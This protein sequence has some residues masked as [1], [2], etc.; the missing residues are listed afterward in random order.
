MGSSSAHIGV[1]ATAGNAARRA[2]VSSL[3]I[4]VGLLQDGG[5]DP[6]SDGLQGLIEDLDNARGLT[7][8]DHTPSLKTQVERPPTPPRSHAT[9]G[10][11]QR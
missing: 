2:V 5:C 8:M 1:D 10:T 3:A 11:G 7:L 4:K 6:C 9:D